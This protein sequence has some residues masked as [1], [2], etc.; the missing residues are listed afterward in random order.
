MSR[1]GRN[2]GTRLKETTSRNDDVVCRRCPFSAS[3]VVDLWFLYCFVFHFFTADSIGPYPRCPVRSSTSAPL[4]VLRSLLLFVC[5]CVCVCV[6]ACVVFFLL[7]LLRFVPAPLT[8][9]VFL[10][11]ACQ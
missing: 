2:T 9:G 3:L 7:R 8:A 5:V 6:C 1:V 10:E 11:G 4:L